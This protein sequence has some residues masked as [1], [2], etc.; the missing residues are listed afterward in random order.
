MESIEIKARLYVSIME[1]ADK[2]W[3]LGTEKV[4]PYHIA[5]IVNKVY[6]ELSDE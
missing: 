3:D 5:I 6:E 2:I 1:N 4:N